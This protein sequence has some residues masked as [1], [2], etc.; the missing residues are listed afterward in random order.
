MNPKSKILFD[1]ATNRADCFGFGEMELS[2]IYFT[3]GSPRTDA[4]HAATFVLGDNV[5]AKR[6]Q[7]GPQRDFG[8]SK[9]RASGP[10]F[11]KDFGVEQGLWPSRG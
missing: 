1:H 4:R 3:P 6:A 2:P 7:K 8:F 11:Y 10:R 9:I 5:Q